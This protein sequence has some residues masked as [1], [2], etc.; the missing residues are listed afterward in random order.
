MFGLLAEIGAVVGNFCR[1]DDDGV[2][3]G[4]Y[5]VGF[6]DYAFS[7]TPGA[8]VTKDGAPPAVSLHSH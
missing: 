3:P 1:V 5:L 6:A 4:P 8:S 7:S 2:R